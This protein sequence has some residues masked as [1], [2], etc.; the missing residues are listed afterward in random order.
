[1]ALETAFYLV[2]EEVAIRSGLVESR[3]RTQD[4]RFVLNN[5]D[6]SRI[7][8][9][10]DEYVNGLEG[11]EKITKEQA[12]KLIRENNYAMGFASGK[13]NENVNAEVENENEN[14]NTE[15]TEETTEAEADATETD[16]NEN[17]NQNEET[18][19]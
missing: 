13:S 15:Q 14:V 17:E 4:G 2:T 19:E 1:M 5:R 10:T 6:L 7:R 16:A 9:S 18:E 3:H 12:K 11:V 8:F